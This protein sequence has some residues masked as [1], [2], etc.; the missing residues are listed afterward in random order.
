MFGGAVSPATAASRTFTT[1]NGTIVNVSPLLADGLTE[2]QIS[3]LDLHV[4]MFDQLITTGKVTPVQAQHLAMSLLNTPVHRESATPGRG[5]PPVAA[6]PPP[7]DCWSGTGASYYVFTQPGYNEQTG[8]VNLGTTYNGSGTDGF[9]ASSGV[10]STATSTGADIGVYTKGN[11]SSAT[12]NLFESGNYDHWWPSNYTFSQSAHPYIYEEV[13]IP[14]PNYLGLT[15]IDAN[16]WTTIYS[17]NV[18][19]SSSYGFTTSGAN[20]EM[21]RM[22]SI[23]QNTENLTDGSYLS[24]QSWS[25]VYEYN[26]YGYNLVTSYGLMAGPQCSSKEVATVKVWSSSAWYASDISITY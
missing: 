4:P 25:N 21:Y 9:Y 11:G 3:A 19:V 2:Q 12:W 16:T 15:I 8:Y 22:D 14:S 26:S 1:S 7:G 13:T 20:D 10:W 18:Y 5:H 6:P 17:V 23:A 24:Y